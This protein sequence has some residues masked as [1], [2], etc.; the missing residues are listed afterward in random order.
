VSISEE[1]FFE[2]ILPLFDGK[3][4]S[5][6]ISVLHSKKISRENTN[7]MIKILFL[8][9]LGSILFAFVLTLLFSRSITDPVN[10]IVDSLEESSEKVTNA[11][12]RISSES[13]SLAENASQ[14]ASSLEESSSS[15]NEMASITGQNADNAQAADHQA[16]EAT[17]NLK[18]ANVSM[19]ALIKSME[20]TSNASIDVSKIIKT[21]DEIAFQTNLLA[22]N[23]AVEAARAGD[24]GSSFAVVADEVRNLAL[25]SAEASQSTQNLIENI[26]QKIETQTNLVL[27]TDDRYREAAI[28]VKKIAELIGEISRFINDQAHGINE[29]NAAV[30]QMDDVV[31]VTAAQAE[32]SSKVS[33]EMLGQ[34]EQLKKIV[35][36]LVA[37]IGKNGAKAHSNHLHGV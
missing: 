17:D 26:I 35:Y 32:E 9:S 6:A 27:E 20:E 13:E 30:S 33:R 10:R 22:L 1:D 11:S 18:A 5:G 31:Q 25:R 2:G 21:I 19:K 28:S 16:K 12:A 7:Q 36:D 15:L 8:I 29:I 24:A 14:Q 34:A 4:V 37:L 3:Q 23:A